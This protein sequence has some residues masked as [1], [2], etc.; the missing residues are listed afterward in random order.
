MENVEL[1]YESFESTGDFKQELTL[2]G[3]ASK[4]FK[5]DYTLGSDTPKHCSTT[6]S[7]MHRSMR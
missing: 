4:K 2:A 7:M 1:S 6:D 3:Q 5:D